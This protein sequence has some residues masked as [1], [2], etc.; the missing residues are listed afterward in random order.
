M[1]WRWARWRHAKKSRGWIQRRYFS[2][3]EHGRF[4]VQT[5]DRQGQPRAQKLYAVG[6][7]IIERHVK[8]Q[9]RPIPIIRTMRNILTSGVAL[10]GGP[11]RWV[12]PAA[13]PSPF[14]LGLTITFPNENDGRITS[15]EA[16]LRK[17]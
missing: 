5:L 4:S 10:P 9:G 16:N 7:T 17:A 2:V 12:Q 8:V 11:I 1:L 6:R 15:A 14:L 3:D 13:T